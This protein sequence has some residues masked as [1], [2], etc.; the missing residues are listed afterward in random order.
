MCPPSPS[1][2][3]RAPD[4]RNDVWNGWSETLKLCLKTSP[5]DA[6]RLRGGL[7]R[8]CSGDALASGRPAPR[9]RGVSKLSGEQARE[10]TLVA[11]ATGQGRIGKSPTRGD[12]LS[13]TLQP[14]LQQPGHRWQAVAAA[15]LPHKR[16]SARARQGSQLVQA[17]RLLDVV[18][19]ALSDAGQVL[20]AWLASLRRTGL[21]RCLTNGQEERFFQ[22]CRVSRFR[23]LLGISGRP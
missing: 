21:R 6:G 13:G 14:Q 5:Q 4:P 15:E 20:A 2:R 8:S 11:E 9:P 1:Q 17:R 3:R 23:G 22:Q 19:K 16:V 7:E 18:G 10:V 12:A